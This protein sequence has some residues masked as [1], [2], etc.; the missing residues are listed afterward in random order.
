MNVKRQPAEMMK[1][2]MVWQ[3]PRTAWNRL[4]PPL[5][6]HVPLAPMHQRVQRGAA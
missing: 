2:A 3:D 1:R 6:L 5:P 4:L